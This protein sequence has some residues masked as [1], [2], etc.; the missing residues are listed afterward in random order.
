VKRLGLNKGRYHG[1]GLDVAEY[2]REFH[3]AALAHNWTPQH[4]ATIDNFELHG[5]RRTPP[6]PRRIIYISTGIHGDEPAGPVALRRLVDEDQWPN[7]ADLI[8]SPCLNPTGLQ[9]K[10]REN[11]HGIDLNRDYREPQSEEVRAHI[12]WLNQLPRFDL[13]LVLH[14]DWEA[15]GYYLYEVNPEKIASPAVH[16]IERVRDLAPIQP[17]ST[18][19]LLWQC[20]SGIIRPNLPPHERPLWAEA[21]Y[22]IVNKTRLSMTLEAPSDFPLPFRAEAHVRA[23]QSALF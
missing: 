13:S 21:V 17:D 12:A 18:I 3:A 4:F 14:E 6:N 11:R 5:Y 19:D 8:L 9:L 10:T 7:D 2:L 20:E 1:E 23:V 22:L 15:D 16:I